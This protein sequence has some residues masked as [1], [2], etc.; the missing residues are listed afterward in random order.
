MPVNICFLYCCKEEPGT[1]HYIL[2]YI[3]NFNE[4]LKMK[5]VFW[6]YFHPHCVRCLKVREFVNKHFEKSFYG[7][8]RC[9]KGTFYKIVINLPQ[10]Q[11]NHK[12]EWAHVERGVNEH[13]KFFTIGQ[14]IFIKNVCAQK[15]LFLKPSL[16]FLEMIW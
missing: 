10:H 5:E 9:L 7:H 1:R 4:K 13:I 16:I 6:L 8:V 12:D 2:L 14:I 15:F 11:S 3:L